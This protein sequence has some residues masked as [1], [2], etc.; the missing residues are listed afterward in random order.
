MEDLLAKQRV[1]CPSAPSGDLPPPVQAK[2][3]KSALPKPVPTIT[4]TTTKKAAPPQQPDKKAPKQA[5]VT[6]P[7]P[8]QVYQVIPEEPSENNFSAE[9]Q[10][11]RPAAEVITFGAGRYAGSRYASNVPDDDEVG[12]RQDDYRDNDQIPE[13]FQDISD[14]D[15][16]AEIDAL[17]Q[18]EEPEIKEPALRAA[19][20]VLQAQKIQANENID[21]D[22]ES[23]VSKNRDKSPAPGEKPPATYVK[24]KEKKEK[25]RNG[26]PIESKTKAEDDKKDDTPKEEGRININANMDL[27]KLLFD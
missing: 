12:G 25:L 1:K 6:K 5:A 7:A 4:V 8:A 15:N 10:S 3:M 18:D 24:I 20:P 19:L 22:R 17:L 2:P 13:D 16:S 21:A 14:N 9:K 26:E 23:N 27:K 11:Y